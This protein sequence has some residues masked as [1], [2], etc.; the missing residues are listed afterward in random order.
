MYGKAIS[1]TVVLLACLIPMAGNATERLDKIR[2]LMEAQGLVATFEQQIQLG[3]EQ[4]EAQVDQLM[5][6]ILG[7]L[8]PPPEFDQKLKEAASEF[9]SAMQPPWSAT[10][11]V[12]VWA[13]HYGSQF[14]DAELDRLVAHYQSPLGQKDVLASRE[15]MIGFS[16]ELNEAYKPTMEAATQAFMERLQQ[17]EKD[18]NCRK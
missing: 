14:T 7:T 13:R 1:M 12:E 15:A 3:R 16:A 5:E 6:Q 10:E 17:I 9:M 2:A 4:A 8:R 18:C 11:I